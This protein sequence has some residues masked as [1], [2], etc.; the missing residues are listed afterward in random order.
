MDN[1][2]SPPKKG[3]VEIKAFLITA[4]GI[5]RAVVSYKLLISENGIRDEERS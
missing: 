2:A 1:A 3:D 4:F 5:R